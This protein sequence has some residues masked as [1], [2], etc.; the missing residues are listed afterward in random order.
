MKL[1]FMGGS[2]YALFTGYGGLKL[3]SV[4]DWLWAKVYNFEMKENSPVVLRMKENAHFL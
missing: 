4:I 2:W 3:S 1:H